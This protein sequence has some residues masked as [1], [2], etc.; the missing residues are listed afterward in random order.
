M[1]QAQAGINIALEAGSDKEKRHRV[2][3]AVSDSPEAPLRCRLQSPIPLKRHSG[4]SCDLRF[5]RGATPV[6]AEVSAIETAHPEAP[7]AWRDRVPPSSG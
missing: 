6:P 3:A 2:P 4:N 5:R 1:S 7:F